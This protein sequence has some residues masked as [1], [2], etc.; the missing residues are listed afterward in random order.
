MGQR[1][2]CALETT[3]NNGPGDDE[4]TMSKEVKVAELRRIGNQDEAEF[5]LQERG[6]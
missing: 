1:N 2:L 3:G 6:K 5:D 4:V